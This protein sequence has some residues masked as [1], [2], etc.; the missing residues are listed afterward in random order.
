MQKYKSWI[1]LGAG[2]F[3]FAQAQSPHPSRPLEPES[4]HRELMLLD[5]ERESV[6]AAEIARRRA[7]ES[8]ERAFVEKANRFALLWTQFATEYNQHKALN[9]KTARELSKAFRDLERE[10]WPKPGA[11]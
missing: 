6:I 9:V 5:L 1:A 4:Y 11:K 10:G 8:R 3:G 7:A 2:L